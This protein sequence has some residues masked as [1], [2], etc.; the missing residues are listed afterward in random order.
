MRTYIHTHTHACARANTRTRGRVRV[1]MRACSHKHA[2]THTRKHTRTRAR[3]RVCVCAPEH[4]VSVCVCACVRATRGC[5]SESVSVPRCARASANVG[6]CVWQRPCGCVGLMCVCL[7]VIVMRKCEFA[8]VSVRAFVCMRRSVSARARAC[9]RACVCC[10]VRSCARASVFCRSI[11]KHLRAC[12]A[13]LCAA[14][15]G[16]CASA[17]CG[18]SGGMAGTSGINSVVA[19]R[20]DRPVVARVGRRCELH[21]SY[22]QGGMG[23]AMGA[24]VGG[25]RRRRH[26]RHRRQQL[27]H[28]L[29]RRVGEHRRRCAAGLSRGGL[30][31]VLGGY[32]RGY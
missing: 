3:A 12:V 32:Y 10:G 4:V 23:C 7:R 29:Q 1:R 11:G 21:Q 9:A 2:H 27:P 19:V 28:L 20:C 26:L 22:P 16:V 14:R 25:R 30:S 13:C 24:H 31:G 6:G 15:L 5:V 17:L 18:R 8:C